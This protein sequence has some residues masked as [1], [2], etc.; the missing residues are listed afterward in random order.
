MNKSLKN[1]LKIVIPERLRL[2][3][4]GMFYGWSGNYPDWAEARSKSDGYDSKEIIEKVRRS[5]ILVRDGKAVF[6]RDSC[7]FNEIEYSYPLLMSL[8]YIAARN[9]GSLNIIDF[10]GALGS[11]YFQNRM[12]LDSL[13]ELKW[14]VVEQPL[15]IETGKNEFCTDRLKFYGSIDEC[16]RENQINVVLFSSVLQYLENPGSIIDKIRSLNVRFILIDRTPFVKGKDRITVQKVNPSIY[17]ASYP[18]WFFNEENFLKYFAGYN[19]IFD[20]KAIDRAN[21]KSE[22]KGFL[23]ERVSRDDG[24]NA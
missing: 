23:F 7:V 17:K 18:C 1:V 14:C 6:E 3:I 10:G 22:F 20:F 8:T 9:K 11:T 24:L 21:I 4:T 12:F 13:P 16:F 19:I 15:F 5:S 2:L